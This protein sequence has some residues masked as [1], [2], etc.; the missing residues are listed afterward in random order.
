MD[1]V[2]RVPNW[3]QKGKSVQWWTMLEDAKAH[4]RLYSQ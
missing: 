4:K 3:S 2:I 1:Q